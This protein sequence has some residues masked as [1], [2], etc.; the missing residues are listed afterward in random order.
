MADGRRLFAPTVLARSRRLWPGG[1][2]RGQALGR[3]RQPGRLRPRRPLGRARA[4]GRCARTGGSGV[5]GRRTRH[6]RAGTTDG[7]RPRR[8]GRG[9]ARRDRGPRPRVGARLRARSDGRPRH[10]RH[11]CTRHR[12]VVGG[13]RRLAPG[14]GRGR[15][16][17]ARSAAP[18]PRWAAGTTH[19]RPGRS[20]RTWTPSTCGAPSTRGTIP[21]TR[22]TTRMRLANRRSERRADP[23]GAVHV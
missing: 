11:L 17:G 12:L 8:R 6:P 1:A 23:R 3:A 16:R 21:P 7:R 9:G 5:L 15:A 18:G 14:P 19:R 13:A 10:P 2:R 4:A 22:P 20:R